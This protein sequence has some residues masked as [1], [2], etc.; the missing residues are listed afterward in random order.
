LAVDLESHKFFPG[1][2]RTLFLLPKHARF[3]SDANKF[4]R[5]IEKFFDFIHGDIIRLLGKSYRSCDSCSS[6]SIDPFCVGRTS[7]FVGTVFELR[8]FAL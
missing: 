6:L 3:N 5:F 7:I 2:R 4:I 8:S 1:A